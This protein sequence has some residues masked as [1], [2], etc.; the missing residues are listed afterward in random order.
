M[1][2]ESLAVELARERARSERLERALHERDRQFE[3]QRENLKLFREILDT[4]TAIIYAKD[5][6]GRILYVNR[7]YERS[8]GTSARDV[9]GQTDDA[10]MPAKIA[11]Q[12]RANDLRVLEEGRALQWEEQAPM[13]DGSIHTF[14]S[15]KFPLTDVRGRPEI[16]CGISTDITQ[17]KRAEQALRESEA[18]FRTLVE[19][20]PQAFVLLD[21]ESLRFVDANENAERLYKLD[22]ASLLA[23]SPVSLS[24]PTQP[25]GTP[26]DVA[27]AA[28]VSAALAGELQVFHWTHRDAEGRDVPCEIRL[29][30]YPAEGRRLVFGTVIDIS[31]RLQAE[32]A[33]RHAKAVAES[34]LAAAEAA[35]HAK[36]QFLASMSH[37]LRTPL[38]GILGYAQLLAKQPRLDTRLREGLES[39][40]CSGEHL[41]TIINDIL[42][43]AKIEAGKLELQIAPFRLAEFQRSLISFFSVSAR[44]KGIELIRAADPDLPTA[45]RGDEKRLRQVLVNLLGNA[46]KFTD[47]G[48]VRLAIRRDPSR[49]DALVFEV[50]DT[51][52]GISREHLAAIFEPFRQ[53][54]DAARASEGTGLG[55]AISRRLITLMGGSLEVVS[56]PGEGSC[57]SFALTL[58]AVATRDAGARPTARAIVGHRPPRRTAL[59]VDD[60]ATN[61]AVLSNTLEQLGLRTIE[62]ENGEQA[63]AL[64]LAERPDVVFMDLKMPVL[65]GFAAIRRI[66]ATPIGACMPIVTI[67]ASAFEH[68]RG[69]SRDTGADAFIAKPFRYDEL[70]AT[71]ERLLELEWVYAGEEEAPIA[72]TPARE[73]VAPERARLLELT[74]L[75]RRGNIPAL[76]RAVSSLERREPTL[77]AF[78]SRLGELAREFKVR[79][80]REFLASF[81]TREHAP[82]TQGRS[83]P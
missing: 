69:R 26:S 17:R 71:L 36:S 60:I 41:L 25:D 48:H 49:P 9:I 67:S 35:N 68:D 32:E 80:I 40:Q 53:V 65:D 23:H 78:C 38:N 72:E 33:L 58:P 66:R 8:L 12:H 83:A 21:V 4:S 57:F 5:V 47:E 63:V 44:S 24:P 73:L 56:A 76:R 14:I 13:A 64:A 74:R 52:V 3:R 7:E 27:A 75:A 59:V 20:A 29:L 31:E 6:D 70:V 18:R 11:A 50:H 54:H 45:A 37:E 30:R 1:S 46:I 61:R 16:V 28:H 10:F 77:A 82:L 42:D 43:L 55:L 51:G 39:I 34:S 22:R 62:A 79:E 81:P 2:R 15:L 19:N